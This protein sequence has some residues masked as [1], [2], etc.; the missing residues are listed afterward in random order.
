MNRK[1]LILLTGVFFLTAV[2]IFA[3][4]QEP[5]TIVGKSFVGK[6]INGKTIREFIGDVVITQKNIRITCDRA[7]QNLDENNA[8]LI[9]NV[10]I[11]Q[12][13][14]VIK[15]PRG[16]YFGNA[17]KA[18][19]N[20]GVYLN[21]G[22]VELFADSGY[23]FSGK[24]EAD[25]YGN[26]KL[27]DSLRTLYSNTLFYF[28]GKDSALA[29]GNVE[30][31]DTSSLLFSDTL[32]Y[33]TKNKFTDARKNVKIVNLK[34]STN[35][36]A[37]H[38]FYVPDSNYTLLTGRPLLVKIDSVKGRSDSLESLDTLFLSANKMESYSDTTSLLVARDSVL[39]VR[40][41][42]ASVSE[43]TFFYRNE[44]KITTFKPSEEG[45]PPV[46]WQGNSQ[47]T[48]D[49][50]SILIKNNSLKEIDVYGNAIIISRNTGYKFR[51]DQLSGDTLKMF[52]DNGE[53]EK[54]YVAG[55]VLS[56]YYLYDNGEPNGLIK[57]SGKAAEIFFE[58]N[59]VSKVKLL[60]MPESEYHP[61]KL[62]K[63][64]E[65]S[66]T[67]PRFYLYGNRPTRKKVI[68]EKKIF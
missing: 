56:I 33:L 23:Y 29:I 2:L 7:I 27:K 1:L 55:N 12:D 46:I 59:E 32:I 19:S 51:F 4:Q 53:L 43:V 21:N 50:I 24:Q 9:G 20:S 5:M 40:K 38:L 42:F 54:T 39:I 36:Y 25:F 48:G 28:N 68:G 30:L 37:E 64:E 65:K 16:F 13:T 61:E 17:K 44:N 49:S 14:I 35:I 22:H 63:G 8:E 34:D 10:V 6:K 62:I 26:V 47:L 3:Q 52:F 57:S 18:Y 66:F 60:G 58:K 15:T 45:N 11:T 41:D 67:L 31:A